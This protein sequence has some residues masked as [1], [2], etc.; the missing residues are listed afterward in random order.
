MYIFNY[1][2]DISIS[3]GVSIILIIVSIISIHASYYM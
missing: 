2:I 3:Q 1:E